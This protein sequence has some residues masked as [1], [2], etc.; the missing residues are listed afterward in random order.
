MRLI[1]LH[2]AGVRDRSKFTRQLGRVLEK[3]LRPLNS[4]L[5][6]TFALF[7]IEKV[8]AFHTL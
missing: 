6:K 4:Y 2:R 3:S 1:R 7:L 5:E 8:I